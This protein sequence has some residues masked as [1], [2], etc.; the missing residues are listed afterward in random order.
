MKV[1]EEIDNH[2]KRQDSVGSNAR[3]IIR[4]LD[5]LRE[6][7]SLQAGVSLGDGRGT[8]KVVRAI[9]DNLPSGFTMDDPDHV[10][11]GVAWELNNSLTDSEIILVSRDINMR[12]MTDALGITAEE[13]IENKVVNEEDGLYT[14]FKEVEMS[15]M[16]IDMFYKDGHI[17]IAEEEMIENEIKENDSVM[18]KSEI[19]EKKTALSRYKN[20]KFVKIRDYNKKGVWGVRARNKEQAFA[21]DLLM[22]QN[23][24]LVSLVGKAGSGKTLMAIAAAIAQTIQDPFD[25]QENLYKKIVLSRPVQPMGKD[26][27]Y[28]PGTMEEKMHPWLMPLQDNLQFLLGNDQATLEEYM[29]KGIIEIEALAYIRGRSI[30]NAF[31]IID[32][33][34]NLT[35]HEI[36]TILTR[37]GENTKIVLTGDV[38]Q[39]D[40]VYVNQTSNG[41]VH[42]VEKFKEYELAGHIT[43]QKGE[44][45]ALATLSSKIL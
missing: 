1:L 40:N 20:G 34:Q 26:I 44:R 11:M 24:P 43:L 17:I 3:G 13:Y 14:G 4:M 7:G 9:P 39:I 28:L 33:A 32:E 19:N 31:I 16:E 38:E 37:V 15:E 6:S 5:S 45:S 30:S 35:L 29:D 21:F 23:I 25:P 12:V 36:K 41:L 22:D 8:L 2:K 27:G 10:I 42:A 18:L